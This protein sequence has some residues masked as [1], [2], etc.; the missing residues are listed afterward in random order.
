MMSACGIYCLHVF[1]QLKAACGFGK[2]S[3]NAQR[4]EYVIIDIMANLLEMLLWVLLQLNFQIEYDPRTQCRSMYS[5]GT[6]LG[7]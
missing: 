1:D 7:L 5:Y 3:L 2:A 6:R 4:V